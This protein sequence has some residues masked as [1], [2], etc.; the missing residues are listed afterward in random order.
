MKTKK[1]SDKFMKVIKALVPII[2]LIWIFLLVTYVKYEKEA[3]IRHEQFQQRETQRQFNNKIQQ[4]VKDME[5]FKKANN[6]E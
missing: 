3:R 6:W 2:I 1:I 5:D 4:A